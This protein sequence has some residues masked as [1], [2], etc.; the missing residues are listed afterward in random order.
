[1]AEVVHR[2][3]H[4]T[5]TVSAALLHCA[6]AGHG[7]PE[8]TR[9]LVAVLMAEPRDRQR[10]AL[11]ALL[12]VGH[13]SGAALA[14]GALLTLPLARA[15]M[16]LARATLGHRLLPVPLPVPASLLAAITPFVTS[17]ATPPGADVRD[18]GRPGGTR[19]QL[20]QEEVA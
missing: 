9:L 12:A 3:A 5:T 15:T 4:R 2:H 14:T 11:T 19:S 1:L 16:P 8:L 13:T 18:H 17:L 10:Q 7:L 6:A 20:S